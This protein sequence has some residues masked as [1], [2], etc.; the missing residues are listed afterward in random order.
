MIQLSHVTAL[1]SQFLPVS[2]IACPLPVAATSLMHKKVFEFPGHKL[3]ASFIG[4][5]STPSLNVGLGALHLLP[6]HPFMA[7]WLNDD[8]CFPN[9]SV[10][11]LSGQN[12]IPGPLVMKCG[13]H[14]LF[15]QKNVGQN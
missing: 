7:T 9:T 4:S 10:S 15:W 14:D 5:F 8:H 1:L 3:T 13:P 2:R 6:D 11:P 12:H